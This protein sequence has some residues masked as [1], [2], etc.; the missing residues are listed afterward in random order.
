MKFNR[1]NYNRSLDD[2]ILQTH[3]KTNSKARKVF[4]KTILFE[5][6]SKLLVV[7]TEGRIPTKKRSYV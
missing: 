4:F 3:R 1:K 6:T 5:T 2:S 7:H